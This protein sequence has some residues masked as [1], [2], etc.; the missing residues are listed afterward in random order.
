VLFPSQRDRERRFLF[1]TSGNCKSRQQR[2]LCSAIKSRLTTVIKSSGDGDRLN[3]FSDIV[4][5]VPNRGSARR[6]RLRLKS[7]SVCLSASPLPVV[8]VL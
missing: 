1:A 2:S 8:G 3:P 6:V 5:V 7:D 4:P